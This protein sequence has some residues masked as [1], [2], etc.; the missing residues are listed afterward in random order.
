MK[1]FD[2]C[3]QEKKEIEQVS[4]FEFEFNE[5]EIWWCSIGL[6][7]GNEED[8]KNTFHERPVLILKKFN[9]HMTWILPTTSNEKQNIFYH[10]L[11]YMHQRFSVILSQLRLISSKRLRRRMV[12]ITERDFISI[13]N[14]VIQLIKKAEP[15]M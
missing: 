12:K 8:G 15:S 9:K 13:Q 5:R 4:P 1:N 6:N 2:V 7:I 3:N 11:F 10:Q 14:K